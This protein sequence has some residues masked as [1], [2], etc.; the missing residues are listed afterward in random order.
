MLS[1]LLQ[2]EGKTPPRKKGHGSLC[3]DTHWMRQSE[4]GPESLRGR[5]EQTP[6]AWSWTRRRSAGVHRS[7]EQ[8]R[9]TLGGLGGQ[10]STCVKNMSPM[11]GEDE[12]EAQGH[13]WK[14][15]KRISFHHL[16]SFLF[17]LSLSSQ[18]SFIRID[19]VSFQ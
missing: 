19:F 7:G 14:N 17:I 5:E 12:E 9:T 2:T 10:E 11:P 15:G 4:P 1:F 13:L 6:G 3:W 8:N 18:S 16:H